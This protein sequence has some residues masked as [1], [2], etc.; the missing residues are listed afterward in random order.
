MAILF[1]L[2]P[3][4]LSPSHTHKLSRILLQTTFKNRH[5]IFWLVVETEEIYLNL[6]SS[7]FQ[8]TVSENNHK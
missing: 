4:S 2:H 3:H 7:P 6:Q 8:H 1:S 5:I